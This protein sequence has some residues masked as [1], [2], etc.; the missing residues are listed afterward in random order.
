MESLDYKNSNPG[1]ENDFSINFSLET[2]KW[3]NCFIETLTEQIM[4][5]VAQKYDFGYRDKSKIL[6]HF[7][8]LSGKESGII[9]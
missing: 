7:L 8:G 3:A 9:I 2:T 1:T 6:S 5:V 4:S